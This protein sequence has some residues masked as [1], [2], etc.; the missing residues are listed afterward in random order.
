MPKCKLYK[1]SFRKCLGLSMRIY[2]CWSEIWTILFFHHHLILSFVYFVIEFSV[3]LYALLSSIPIWNRKIYL[4][5]GN[6]SCSQVA[7]QQSK[8]IENRNKNMVWYPSKSILLCGKILTFCP[9]S[10]IG[11]K[12]H[13]Y[14]LNDSCMIW[15]RYFSKLVS[16]SSFMEKDWKKKIVSSRILF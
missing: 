16:L 9:V 4:G 6:P 11:K 10:V 1:C 5:N 2:V 14:I 8:E 7:M 12:N 3:F 13:I 15:T